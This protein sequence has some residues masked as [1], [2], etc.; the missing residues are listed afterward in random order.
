MDRKCNCSL[1]SKVNIKCIYEGK[2]WSWCINYKV[3]CSVCDAIYIGN[4]QQN[5]KKIMNGHFSDLLCLLKKIKKSDS[6]AAQFEQ[7]L[8]TTMSC[9]YLRKYMMFKVVKQINL[10]GAMKKFTKP[11][12]YLCMQESLTILKNLSDKRITV[13]NQ[14]FEIYG[15]CRHKTTFHQ[16]C[17][18]IDDPV[19]NGWKG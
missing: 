4:T 6:F 17:L 1:P 3:K 2:Y 7:H 14:S 19:F 12:C 13:M 5:F 10:I 15:A 8:N 9:T 11:N 18:S 16:F